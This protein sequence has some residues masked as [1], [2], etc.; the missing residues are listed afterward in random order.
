MENPLPVALDLP[1]MA[2]DIADSDFPNHYIQTDFDSKVAPKTDA[3]NA[4]SPNP[5][6]DRSDCHLKGTIISP[7]SLLP[8]PEAP[9]G[10]LERSLSLPETFDSSASAIGKFFREKSNS[11]SEAL[12]RISSLTKDEDDEESLLVKEFN[13]VGVKVV[14]T[15]KQGTKELKG[16]IS[17][18]SRSNCRDCTAVRLFLR[19]RNLAY[20]E[21]NIDVYP[22]RGKELRERTGGASVP[23]LF[24]NEKLIGGL[25][26]LNSL[27][28]SGMLEGKMEEILGTKCPEDAPA[29]PVYGFDEEGEVV[30][31]DEMAEIVRVVRQR[32]PIQDR[33][34]KMKFV[35]NCF[36][37][38]EL[39]E[40]LI[41][42][43]D[44]GRK[45]AVE[46]GKQLARRH[47][48]HHVF[49]DN[50]FED[51]NHFYRFLEHE[52]FIPKCYN[53]R[54]V[55]NDSEP[56]DAA[57]V[58]RRLTCIM[59]AILESYASDDRLY[60]DYLGIS[61]S[62]EFR[63]YINVVEELQRVDLLTLS[64]DEKLAFFLNLHNSMAIHAVIRIGHP[65]GMIDRRPFFSDFMYV[66]GG[67][68]Y[69]L[70]SIRNGIL[71]GNRRPPFS[72]IKPFSKGDKRL[73]LSFDK[74]NQLI[75]FGMWNATR[76]SPSIRFFKC[77]GIES[78]LKNAAREYFQREDGMQ[79]DLAKRTVY[80]PRIFKWY[81]ADFGEEKDIP[82]WIINY[83][84]AS[85]AGLLTHLISDGGS[86]NIAYQDYDW[87]LNL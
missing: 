21:I 19:E 20:V 28:N 11:V 31:M 43:L 49:G 26:A 86:V 61:N 24:F 22:G 1:R 27:R 18:F 65:G 76:G 71:R 35:K 5:S 8:K 33:I 29:P 59:S 62:E 36:S 55:V 68:P 40:E 34:T 83:L 9:P 66:I 56:K 46:I 63:R 64:Q 14:K 17:F 38:A 73:E 41:H 4:N 47:F 16:R 15:L 82:N 53:F 69:S 13:L 30:V 23:Q 7:H 74:V 6:D 78:E 67:H 45:K 25:V 50:E 58:S 85:K 77:Q 84:D 52:P 87:S 3:I 79:V 12:K 48:I 70:N 75:H 72:L 42:Q 57:A 32:V 44:C 37:G 60:L 39:V 10:L 51:G 2:R 80:L 54:G 81:S